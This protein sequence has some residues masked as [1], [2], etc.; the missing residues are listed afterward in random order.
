MASSAWLNGFLNTTEPAASRESLY[1]HC[2][3]AQVWRE[4]PGS[5]AFS[6]FDGGG[7]FLDPMIGDGEEVAP[8]SPIWQA[9]RCVLALEARSLGWRMF[10]RPLGQAG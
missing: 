2:D 8:Q 5:R 6:N 9:G 1:R 4:V 3:E 7:S 10:P